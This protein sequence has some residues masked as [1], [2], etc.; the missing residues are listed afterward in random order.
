V[1]T[2]GH[3]DYPEIE[4]RVKLEVAPLENTAAQNTNSTESP[5]EIKK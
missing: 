2:T 1:L 5:P 3:P 4:L